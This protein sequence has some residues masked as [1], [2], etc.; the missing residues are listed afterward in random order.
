MSLSILTVSQLNLYVKS[1]LESNDKLRFVYL[2]GEI[3]N[4]T[5]H[6]RSGHIYLTL[7]DEKSTIKA[8]MFAG[9]ARYLKFKPQNGMVV[10]VRGRVSLYEAAG[11][12]QIYIEDMQPDGIG[13]LNLAFEQ[14]KK[15]LSAEGLFDTAHKKKLPIL[16]QKIGVITSPTGAAFQDICRILKRRYPMGDII[17]CPVLVQGENSAEQLTDAVKK[18]NRLKCADVII[19]GRG[20]GSIEDLW[21]FNDEELARAI[22][23]SDIPIVSAVGHETD[24]TICDFV[25]D[26]RASTPSA[27]A[28]LVSPEMDLILSNLKYY[29]QKVINLFGKRLDYERERLERFAKSRVMTLPYE[30]IN[31]KRINLD[32]ISRAMIQSYSS[33]I[34]VK[35]AHFANINAKLDALSPLKVLSRGYSIASK[36][37]D[38]IKSVDSV[39]IGDNIDVKVSDG[40]FKCSV[41]L[42]V[43]NQ[44]IKKGNTENEKGN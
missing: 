26:V 1:L 43:P 40:V 42:V 34:S 28:E 24:F 35:R 19:I 25:S 11:A 9:N 20:G 3:S 4:L 21:A 31:F 15:R 6:Q 23:E 14:L 18:F 37:N 36:G 39:N 17:L 32:K 8:V 22:Y 30:F 41:S 5:D 7:K 2:K 27:G 13:A 38:I 29:K 16:P 12:Y 44:T 10:L 33:Q